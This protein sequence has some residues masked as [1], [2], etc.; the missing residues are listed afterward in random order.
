[1]SLGACSLE[2]LQYPGNGGSLRDLTVKPRY[3]LLPPLLFLVI[4]LFLGFVGCVHVLCVWF[5]VGSWLW[6]VVESGGWGLRGLCRHQ[7]GAI[8]VAVAVAVTGTV[9]W[10]VLTFSILDA[11]GELVDSWELLAVSR[12]LVFGSCWLYLGP[13]LPTPGSTFG[14][15]SQ[16]PPNHFFYCLT[17]K[18]QRLEIWPWWMYIALTSTPTEMK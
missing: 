5:L 2:G 3:W 4:Y 6:V 1:M 7:D 15:S 11:L 16:D 12:T 10:T 17:L 13:Y 8:Q 9:A 14:W 18:Y